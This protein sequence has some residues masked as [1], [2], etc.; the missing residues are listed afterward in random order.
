MKDILLTHKTRSGIPLIELEPQDGIKHKPLVIMMHGYTG[1]KEFLLIQ[2][3]SLCTNGFFVVLPDAWGHGQRAVPGSTADFIDSVVNTACDINRLLLAYKADERVDID[4]AGLAGFSMGGCIIFK[5]LSGGDVKVR[6]A[7]PVIA[8]PDWI[9]ILES[10]E[11][12][13]LMLSHGIIKN[14]NELDEMKKRAYGIQPKDRLDEFI[15]VPLLIQNG[16]TDTLIPI[17]P[18]QEYY[19]LIK[20]SY[21]DKSEISFITYPGVGHIDNVAM[22]M[23]IAA[24]MKKHLI[25]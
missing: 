9:S 17:G 4:K 14:E 8:T 3:Y 20:R 1:I 19:D 11:G 23:R 5:Y 6:A 18:V 10:K 25:L 16:E 12:L 2:A 24:F 22:N 15:P 13:S 21:N 7:A